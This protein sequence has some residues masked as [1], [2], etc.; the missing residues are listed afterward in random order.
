[1]CLNL[2]TVFLSFP[3][4]FR[5]AFRFGLSPVL[6]RLTTFVMSLQACSGVLLTKVN[7]TFLLVT[8]SVDDNVLIQ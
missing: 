2:W 4:V 7:K 1:M 6:T 5:A 3:N 8:S